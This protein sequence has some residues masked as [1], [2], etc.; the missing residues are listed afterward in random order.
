MRLTSCRHHNLLSIALQKYPNT[1]VLPTPLRE[2]R[3][4]QGLCVR[5]ICLCVAPLFGVVV[6]PRSRAKIT[7]EQAE[8]YMDEAKIEIQFDGHQAKNKSPA[9]HA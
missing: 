2:T 1:W 5:R 9:R 6:N 4:K 8:K 3:A 7:A